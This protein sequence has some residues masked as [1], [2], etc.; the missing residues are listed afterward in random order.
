MKKLILFVWH[1]NQIPPATCYGEA[2][3]KGNYDIIVSSDPPKDLA[4]AKMNGENAIVYHFAAA[5][6]SIGK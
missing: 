6:G 5:S 4:K 1:E 3:A 2:H